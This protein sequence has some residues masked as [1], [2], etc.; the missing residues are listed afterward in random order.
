VATLSV[1]PPDSR[2]AKLLAVRSILERGML[3]EARIENRHSLSIAVEQRRA[4]S[5]FSELAA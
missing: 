3:A 1:G 5:R 2:T 4:I